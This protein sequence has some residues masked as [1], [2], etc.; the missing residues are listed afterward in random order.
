M[1]AG[2]G[3]EWARFLG[4][5]KVRSQCTGTLEGQ[6]NITHDLRHSQAKRTFTQRFVC[7]AVFS[8]PSSRN[9][10][11]AEMFNDRAQTGG[12]TRLQLCS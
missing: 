1:A 5:S 8:C 12:V 2:V 3:G 4:G 10:L 9:S 7:K 6:R 11:P